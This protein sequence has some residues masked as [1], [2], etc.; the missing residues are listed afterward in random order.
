[1]YARSTTVRGDPQTLGQGIDY[2]RDEVMPLVRGMDGCMG[3]SMLCDRTTGR[4]IITTSWE[5]EEAMR[6]S[7]DGVRASRA[8]A[9]EILGD[10]NPEVQEWEIAVMHRMHEAHNGARTRVIWGRR[11]TDQMDRSLEDFRTGM[12][13]RIEEL[14]GFCSLSLMV[15]RLDGRTATAVTYDSPDAMMRANDLATALREEFSRSLGM[16]ITA[17]AEFDLVLAHLRVPETV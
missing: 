4:C 16:E 14:P 11:G 8:R 6:D 9:A 15:D 5:T 12:L 7:A 2:V 1:M 17:V 13:P 10:A 3:L